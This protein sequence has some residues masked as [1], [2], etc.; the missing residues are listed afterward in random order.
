MSTSRI[1]LFWLI[2]FTLT[3]PLAVVLS[4]HLARASFE[5]IKLRGQ[6]ITVKG[7]A[8]RPI[9][10]DY[11]EWSAY[12]ITRHADRTE[13]YQELD[14][15]RKQVLEYLDTAGFSGEQVNLSPV[16]ITVVYKRNE[17]GARTNDIERYELSLGFA[18][19]GKE[20]DRI[21]KAPLV[22]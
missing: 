22:G 3:L 16:D 14:A 7:Y 11:A 21:T 20:V 17:K 12:V 6:T 13:A 10:S 5:K 1:N 18:I 19:S 9:V 2:I 15:Q 8:E 4:T